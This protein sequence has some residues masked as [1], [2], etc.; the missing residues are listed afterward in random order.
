APA[1][2]STPRLPKVSRGQGHSERHPTT[3]SE[4]RPG[5][6]PHAWSPPIE[7]ATASPATRPSAPRPSHPRRRST[8]RGREQHSTGC[9]FSLPGALRWRLGSTPSGGGGLRQD[10]ASDP[11]KCLHLDVA[12]K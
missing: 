4:L 8:S 5:G 3:C 11:S 9:S 12:L 1:P 10:A 6:K 7:T 2:C